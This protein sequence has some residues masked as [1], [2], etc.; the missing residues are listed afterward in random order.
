MNKKKGFLPNGD[1]FIKDEIVPKI[2]DC[3]NL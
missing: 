1:Y 2:G 3:I